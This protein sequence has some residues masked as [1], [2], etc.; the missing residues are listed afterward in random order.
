MQLVQG[1]A[2]F[3]RFI[4][5]YRERIDPPDF[6]SLPG[7]ICTLWNERVADQLPGAQVPA[8]DGVLE[9]RCRDL[10]ALDAVQDRV[11]VASAPAAV[12][13][14]REHVVLE[15]DVPAG[16]TKGIFLFRRRADLPLERFQSYWLN[17]HGPIASRTPDCLRYVQCHLLHDE[18]SDGAPLYDG[19]TELYW[20]SHERMID[21]MRS[22]E[23][24]VEQA[25]D[26]PNFVAPGS[27][28]I[29]MVLED[30]RGLV[31]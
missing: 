12:L 3:Y 5:L 8:F 4:A 13:R 16:V 29:L 26:A 21:S 23:M 24:T 22:P 10:A 31:K 14:T 6:S 7:V 25:G 27:V 20:P 2:R 18:Y 15:R 9:V 30:V 17:H 1:D 19:V 11:S 28:D